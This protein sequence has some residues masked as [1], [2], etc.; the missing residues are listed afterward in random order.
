MVG[1]KNRDDGLGG[2]ERE[3]MVDVLGFAGRVRDFVDAQ[4][5]DGLRHLL[6]PALLS[7]H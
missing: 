3:D 7:R 1:V 5:S 2:Y 6:Q 4:V